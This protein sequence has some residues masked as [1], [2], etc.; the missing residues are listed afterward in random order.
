[1]GLLTGRHTNVNEQ[2]RDGTLGFL[3]FYKNLLLVSLLSFSDLMSCAQ[4]LAPLNM[5]G[6]TGLVQFDSTSQT[7]T[8]NISGAGSCDAVNLSLSEFPV[9]YGHF[10]HPC[11]EE[12]IGSSIFSIVAPSKSTINVSS[13]FEQRS[14]LD[15]LS[16]SLQMCNGTKVCT[17]VS[18]GQTVLTKQA[19]FTGSIAGN[20]Y[21]R[22]N[23][24]HTDP[25]LLADLMTVSHTANSKTNVTLYGSQSTAASC[26]V[27]LES[28]DPLVLTNLGVVKVGNPL[29]FLKSRLDLSSFNSTYGFL[30]LRAGSTYECAQL[31]NV[32]EKQV[33]AVLSMK[34]ITGYLSFH[35]ASPFDVTNIRVDLANLE[36]KVGPYHIHQFPVPSVRSSRCSNDNVAGHW[37]PFAINTRDPSY[38]KVPG[39]THDRYEMGDL[40]AK[41]MSLADKNEVNVTFADFNLPLFGQNSI[42]GRSVVIHQ[43]DGVRYVCASISYPG[44]VIVARAIFQGPV[45]GEIWFTQLVS[46]PLS[47]VSIFMD[48]SY[49]DATMTPTKNHNFHVHLY[50]ISS[51]RDDDANRCSTTGGHWNPFNINT[52]DSSYA[53]HCGPYRPFYCEVGDLSNKH[54]TIDLNTRV[55][56]VE[57]KHFFTDVTSWLHVPGI[58]GRSVVIHASEKGGT[59]IACSNVTMARVPRAR[60]GQWFGLGLSSSQVKFSQALPEGPTTINVSLLNLDSQAGGYHVHILPIKPDS[61]EPCSNDDIL[62]H[63]NPLAWNTSNSPSP[64][65]GTMDQ[66]EIGDISGKFGMLNDRNSLEAVYEDPDMPLTGPNSIVGRSLVV[67]FASGAR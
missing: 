16:L 24:E 44:E 65:A 54:T 12:N 38:P 23:L 40:S 18:Q 9:M 36:G 62:G 53:L 31:H 49:G 41:H 14:K 35:Q 39:S 64:G 19:R 6:V 29:L 8:V 1:M 61:P 27:L 45:V 15:D 59:R 37:N 13:L 51:E 26:E 66:Y 57:A 3:S 67:H 50:P 42:V 28:L 46:H 30:L 2:K 25:R 7:A 43:T 11:S 5:E 32:E 60:L 34:G 56:G 17:V 63:F 48:L 58:I 47:D 33:K 55:G 10:H 4:F 22:F 20:I 52:S 21:I